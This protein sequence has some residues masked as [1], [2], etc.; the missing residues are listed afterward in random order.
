MMMNQSS[1]SEKPLVLQTESLHEESHD[2]LAERVRLVQCYE[3]EPEFEALLAEAVGLVIRTY[4]TVDAAFL[5]RAPNLKVV[6]RAG[7]GVDNIDLEAC[8]SRRITVVH[9]PESNTTAVVEFVLTNLFDAIRPR[10]YMEEGCEPS[11]WQVLRD[12]HAGKRQLDEMTVGI[13]GLGRIGKRLAAAIGPLSGRC[14]YHDLLDIPPDQRFGAEP[15]DRETLLRES[16]ILSIHVDGRPGNRDLIDE[17]ALA[18]V[19]P[20]V[21]LINTSRG[22]VVNAVHLSQFMIRHMDAQAWID[23]HEPEPIPNNYA[24][25]WTMKSF[26]TPHLAGRTETALRAMSEVVRDVWAVLDGREPKWPV[27]AL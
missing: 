2:W 22:F 9:T 21:I 27:S 11:D 17:D 6:G 23:V 18:L 16:D 24:L 3:D 26:L 15:V 1:E 7:V 4:T 12:Q 20:E 5:D 19:K 10:L 25:F 8:Q 13:Y 14:V